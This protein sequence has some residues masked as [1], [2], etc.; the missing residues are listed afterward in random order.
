MSANVGPGNKCHHVQERGVQDG[1]PAVPALGQAG[2]TLSPL[3]P[4][5]R[6]HSGPRATQHGAFKDAWTEGL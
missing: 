4:P 6:V 3:T 1:Q 5:E 2:H